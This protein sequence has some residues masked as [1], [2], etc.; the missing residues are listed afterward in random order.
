M[1]KTYYIEASRHE[2]NEYR[3][4]DNR[5]AAEA[6]YH[7][8][9]EAYQQMVA[10]MKQRLEQSS[11][12]KL[13]VEKFTPAYNSRQGM[14]VID[15]ETTVSAV[16]YRVLDDNEVVRQADKPFPD[17]HPVLPYVAKGYDLGEQAYFFATVDSRRTVRPYRAASPEAAVE[18]ARADRLGDVLDKVQPVRHYL[19]ADKFEKVTLSDGTTVDIVTDDD[20]RRRLAE[21]FPNGLTVH[22]HGVDYRGLQDYCEDNIEDFS[23]DSSWDGTVQAVD[24]PLVPT[25]GQLP[26]EL[27][28]RP[29]DYRYVYACEDSYY[30]EQLV[31]L[32]GDENI[33]APSLLLAR[34]HA[35]Q[36]FRVKIPKELAL[37]D[38]LFVAGTAV[39]EVMD[40][41]RQNGVTDDKG[42]LYQIDR[43][44]CAEQPEWL[45]LLSRTYTADKRRA[46]W[47]SST[48]A[49]QAA[50]R[51][52]YAAVTAAASRQFGAA[53][54]K[55]WQTY[56]DKPESLSPQD[57]DKIIDVS[58]FINEKIKPYQETVDRA[59]HGFDMY[60]VSLQADFT[61]RFHAFVKAKVKDIKVY[62][63]RQWAWHVRCK[64]DG[65]QQMAKDLDEKEARIHKGGNVAAIKQLVAYHYR[66]EIAAAIDSA[67]KIQKHLGR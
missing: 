55:L 11:D 31:D 63:D 19:H 5:F 35:L 4:E 29:A 32:L 57:L 66:D 58:R 9:L 10:S 23:Q 8:K 61:R 46:F 50:Y 24:K 47:V 44:F 49:A 18:L 64:I 48:A 27:R 1:Q 62:P 43:Q 52:G 6:Y 36:S 13:A 65:E 21:K 40:M 41:A 59:S 17:D 53:V 26:A 16:L 15:R 14:F 45:Q 2:K 39:S 67:E 28:F 54:Y 12:G 33:T 38:R 25:D 60:A 51:Q 34:D 20:F 56:Q 22:L 42:L 3:V 7:N 37:M 30:D